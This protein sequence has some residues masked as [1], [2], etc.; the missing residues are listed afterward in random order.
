MTV[1]ADQPKKTDWHRRARG[2][3]VAVVVALLVAGSM[4]VPDLWNFIPRPTRRRLIE[5]FLFACLVGYGVLLPLSLSGSIFFCIQLVRS[6]HRK[7]NWRPWARAF[8]ACASILAMLIVAEGGLAGRRAIGT[9]PDPR[10]PRTLPTSPHNA[11]RVVVIGSSSARGYP[12]H[13]RLSV[14]QI[15]AWR[16]GLAVRGRRVDLEILAHGGANLEGQ[17]RKLSQIKYK[18]DALIIYCGHNEIWTRY[19]WARRV[20]PSTD[21]VEWTRRRSP[22]ARLIDEAIDENRVDAPPRAALAPP[23]IDWPTCDGAERAECLADFRRRMEQIL[24]F[25]SRLDVLPILVIPPCNEGDW[26]PSRTVMPASATSEER[27]A[28][29]RELESARTTEGEQAAAAYESL[30]SRWPGLAEAHFRL[31]RL[32]AR[33]GRFDEARRHFSAAR[34]ADGFVSRCPQAFQDVY[35]DLAAK[36]TILIDGPELLRAMS[37]DGILDFNLF[38]DAHHPAFRA[39]VAL[40]AAIVRAMHERGSLGW[41]VGFAPDF[42]PAECAAH[43]KMD[44]ARRS[45]GWAGACARTG[46]AIR[47]SAD[48]LHDPTERLMWADRFEGAANA[49]ESGAKPEHLGIPGLGVNPPWQRIADVAKGRRPAR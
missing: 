44:K 24:A 35:R 4:V 30:L 28:V 49:L 12:Y 15:V 36:R 29:A 26:E 37:P 18:P 14:G 17:Y 43:F 22:L 6:R 33:R 21:V 23:M 8:L 46:T 48:E 3:A 2:L 39:H 34:E 32:L 20:R 38:H 27:D 16:L 11:L 47:I 42:D 40:A 9:L 1:T 7:G 19:P 31:A 13:P 10:L 45:G 25:C 5:G 41:P